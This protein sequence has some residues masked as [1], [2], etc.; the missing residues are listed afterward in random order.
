MYLWCNIM[1]EQG[2]DRRRFLYQQGL[3]DHLSQEEYLIIMLSLDKSN[4]CSNRKHHSACYP[5]LERGVHSLRVSYDF[6]ETGNCFRKL[7][8]VCEPRRVV[9]TRGSRSCCS[10]FSFEDVKKREIYQLGSSHTVNEFL[11]SDFNVKNLLIAYVAL[12]LMDDMGKAL[13]FC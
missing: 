2:N 10:C 4:G 9:K 12:K 5:L 3:F 13:G 6:F 7:I 1:V 11:Q 8:C